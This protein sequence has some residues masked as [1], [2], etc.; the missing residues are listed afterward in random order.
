MNSED[1]SGTSRSQVYCTTGA[2]A[3]GANTVVITGTSA[4]PYVIDAIALRP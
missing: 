4:E 2:V 1:T 3:P